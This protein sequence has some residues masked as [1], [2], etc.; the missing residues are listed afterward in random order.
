MFFDSGMS[1]LKSRNNLP[2]KVDSQAEIPN[3]ICEVVSVAAE[4]E[5]PYVFEL[6]ADQRL[7]FSVTSTAEIDVVM[8][9]EAAYD[10]WIDNGFKSEHPPDS[11]LALRSSFDHSMEFAPKRVTTLVAILIN[12]GDAPV[13]AIVGATV[14]DRSGTSF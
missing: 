8:C 4:D 12:R 2:L 10:E 14:L 3:G 13:D 11:I 5:L 7:S 6:D 1:L 9:E